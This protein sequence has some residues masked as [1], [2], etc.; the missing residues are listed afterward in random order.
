[1]KASFGNSI[2]FVP[3]TVTVEEAREALAA[4]SGARDVF[5][6]AGGERNEPIQGM[7]AN[8]D[9]ERPA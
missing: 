1:V 7:V 4:V 5:I 2:V 6:T 8:T 9:L 3:P